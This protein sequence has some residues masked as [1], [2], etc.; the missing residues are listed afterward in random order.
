M[1]DEEKI[2]VVI[3]WVDG[4]DRKWQKKA[5]KY[6]KK[7]NGERYRDWGTLRYVLRS[8]EKYS[9]W[10][11]KVYLVTDDQKPSWLN[12]KCDK[13]EVIDHKQ[14]IP[15]ECLPTFNSN[16]ITLNIHKI[17][18]LA[19][20]FI[21][22]NDEFIFS[23]PVSPT[24]FFKNS[25]PCDFYVESPVLGLIPWH[26]TI[27]N[28]VILIN[29]K[30]SKRK[31]M[32][33]EPNKCF[34]LLYGKNNLK[35]L[36]SL[37]YSLYTGFFGDHGPQ[38]YLKSSFRAVWELYKSQLEENNTH[39]TRQSGDDIPDYLVRYYQL[40]TGNFQ[41][42]KVKNRTMYYPIGKNNFDEIN[43]AFRSQ[44]YQAIVLNDDDVIKVKNFGFT[45]RGIH[46]LLENN[47]P[48]KSKFEK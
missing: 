14:I 42:R 33:K 37:P 3:P 48:H 38:P 22:M 16:V 45:F 24:D 39:H 47:F 9:P 40:V 32:K 18:G 28:G 15:Q 17:P 4:S 10:V 44:K 2:D 31:F 34:S 23:A 35:T 29:Q 30:F 5:S 43:D 41:P 13:I 36:F 46:E 11:H 25:L 21:N 8:I 7:F 12:E 19:E 20:K 27:L 1:K 6:V 26:K